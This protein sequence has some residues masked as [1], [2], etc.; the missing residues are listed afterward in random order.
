MEVNRLFDQKDRLDKP[1]VFNFGIRVHWIALLKS[2]HRSIFSQLL[3][4]WIE[5]RTAALFL[6]FDETS[7]HLSQFYF[8][9]ESYGQAAC[10]ISE[11]NVE[12]APLFE[13]STKEGRNLHFLR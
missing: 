1:G 12:Q 7:V 13:Q 5:F 4:V 2:R 9:F 3:K 6:Q 8:H 10:I 11:P